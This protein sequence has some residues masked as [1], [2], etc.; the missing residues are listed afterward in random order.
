MSKKSHLFIFTC[1]SHV[2]IIPLRSGYRMQRLNS[3]DEHQKNNSSTE[4]M[5]AASF[6]VILGAL[7]ILSLILLGTD[8]WPGQMPRMFV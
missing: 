1:S 6:P 4:E 2:I 8:Q 7:Y 3:P 5:N